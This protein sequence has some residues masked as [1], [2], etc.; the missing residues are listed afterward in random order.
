MATLSYMGSSALARLPTVFTHAEALANGI[1]DRDLYRMCDEGGIERLARGI[2]ARPGLGADPDLV[3]IAVRSS[4]ATLCLTSA[5]AH[6]DLSDDI[7]NQI[8][9]ALPRSQRSPRTKAPIRWHRFDDSTF[10]VG[11]SS[12][13]L[14]DELAIGIYSPVRSIIDAYRLRHLYGSEQA[15]EA[16]KRWLR[17]QANQP[18]ELLTMT[19]Q[20]PTAAATLR[21]ALEV[22]L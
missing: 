2:Y 8:N 5:L 15:H 3:E 17:A 20:F 11:R 16:L 18:A 1:S 14:T 10:E 6:H 22:L 4:W 21:T 19:K 13:P 7:P 9:V 12:L